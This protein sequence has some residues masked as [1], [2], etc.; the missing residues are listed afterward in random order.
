MYTDLVN[1]LRTKYALKEL[2]IATQLLG[3]TVRR[4]PSRGEIHICQPNLTREFGAFMKMTSANK[5]PTPYR[6]GALLHPTE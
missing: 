5:A 6:S 4:D 3:W 1:V 2:G